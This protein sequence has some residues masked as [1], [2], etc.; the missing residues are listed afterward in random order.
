MS[1]PRFADDGTEKTET[2]VIA[3]PGYLIP[4]ALGEPVPDVIELLEKTLEE[5]K[6]GIVTAVFLAL[7]RH[8]DAVSAPILDG[9]FAH[10]ASESSDLWLAITRF[11][12]KFLSYL[13]D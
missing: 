1:D 3:M 5:A 6:A 9:G 7:I 4:T 11:E 2:N 8:T 10:R 13:F 12:R